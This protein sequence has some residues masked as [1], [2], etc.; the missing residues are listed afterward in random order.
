M[1]IY[2]ETND[3]E[4]TKKIQENKIVPDMWIKW[5]EDS[6]EDLINVFK[7]ELASPQF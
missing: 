4:D 1:A 5:Q 6:K 2:P 7:L 3:F